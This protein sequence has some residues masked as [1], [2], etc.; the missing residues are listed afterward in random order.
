MIQLARGGCGCGHGCGAAD[1]ARRGFRGC[2]GC[3]HGCG[4]ALKASAA[5]MAAAGAGRCGCGWEAAAAAAGAGAGRCCL[6]WG[7]CRF[8]WTDCI[9]RDGRSRARRYCLQSSS[10]FVIEIGRAYRCQPINFIWARS[11]LCQPL[12]QVSDDRGLCSFIL[13]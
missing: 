4:G 12:R 9:D 2:G 11:N 1:M 3:G 5:D 6:S 8:C 10:V 7:G 13:R